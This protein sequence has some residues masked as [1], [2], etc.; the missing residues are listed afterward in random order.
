[1]SF[2]YTPYAIPLFLSAAISGAL[3]WYSLRRRKQA[4]AFYF[5]LAML[6]LSWWA[7]CYGLHVC[8]SDLPTQYLFNRLKYVGVMAIP[9]LWVVLALQYT[10]N[11][12]YLS[13]RNVLLLFLPGAILLFVVLTNPWT[14]LWWPSIWVEDFN[15]Y[16]VFKRTHGLLYYAHTIL[17]YLYIIVGLGIY[18]RFYR[19][20]AR[21]YRSQSMLMIIAAS[22]PLVASAL[23]QIGLS[24]LPWGLDPFFFTLSG[25][26]IA[27]AIFRYRFLD[28]IPVAR[29]AIVDQIPEGVIVIDANHRIVDVNPAARTM[30]VAGETEMIG[31]PLDAAVQDPQL[32]QALFQIIKPGGQPGHMQDVHLDGRVLSLRT[33][34]LLHEG[35]ESVGQII[36]LEDITERIAAQQE[37]ETL[38]REA[39]LQRERLALIISN[40]SDAIVLFDAEAKILADNPA[41]RK[42]L[43]A[44]HG[45][46]LPP[47]LQKLLAQAQAT[48]KTANAEISL[49]EQTFHVLIAPVPGTG[50]VLTM[51][52]VTHF[53]KLA[54]MKDE[55][56]KTVSH[57]MRAPLTSILGYAQ[58]AQ[59]GSA[60]PE[61][62]Q[63]AMQRIETSVWRM[64]KLINDMLDLAHLESDIELNL[65]SVQLGRLARTASEDLEEEAQAKGLAFRY[66]L[67]DHP[68]IQADPQR[69]I[70]VWRNLVENAV[71]YTSQGTITIRVETMQ[72][73]VLGQVVD[74]GIGIQPID[75]PYVFD[76]FFRAENVPAEQR[77]G[78]G[79]GLSMAKLIVEKHGGRIWVESEVGAGSAFTFSLPLPPERSR[80]N[81]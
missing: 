49:G 51:H 76:K 5:G 12:R 70:Q 78:A 4:E 60:S 54:E 11:Q 69:I 21:I 20:T 31:Q 47:A 57:D 33:T 24:P 65:A 79:L 35:D 36:L 42:I 75:A 62:R 43:P 34:P 55:F 66:E 23:T 52:D 64:S 61:A 45:E 19:R 50:L 13:R 74:T 59:H 22:I 58:I 30:L 81:E 9:P 18:V 73:Q 39:E 56:V 80:A 71:K 41:A 44:G 46:P 27:I 63:K 15:G 7:L 29:R 3:A 32:E 16:P 40:A 77:G 10:Q 26:L 72:K 1:M 8:A 6:A 67:Y 17:S 68:P 53:Q 38:Y 2:H 25:A 14:H 48:S 28:I 37:L